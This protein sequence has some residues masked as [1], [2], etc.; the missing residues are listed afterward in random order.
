MGIEDPG[1]GKI[2]LVLGF[3]SILLVGLFFARRNGSN[4]ITKLN[5]NKF[6]KLE[7]TISISSQD[8]VSIVTA[9]NSRYLIIH[10]K[11]HQPNVT[12]LKNIP[13]KQEKLITTLNQDNLVKGSL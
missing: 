5:N 8:R 11:G 13:L 4:F 9:D 10:G 3:I 7:E 2:I 6:I 12:L 1:L